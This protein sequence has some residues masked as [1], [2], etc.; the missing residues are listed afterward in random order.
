MPDGFLPAAA[1]GGS[2]PPMLHVNL[3]ARDLRDPQLA[4]EVADLL[5]EHGAD[6]GRITIEVTESAALDGAQALATLHDLRKL[7]LRVSLDD[8]GTGLSTLSLLHDCPVDEIKLDRSFTQAIQAPGA[9]RVPMAAAVVHLARVLGMHVVAEGVETR[10]QA[11]RLL[12]L[13]YA[14]A[15]GNWFAEPASPEAFAGLLAGGLPDRGLRR[16]VKSHS[17][18]SSGTR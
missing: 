4:G 12:A 1:P 18:A 13:G 7:G 9:D 11:E 17:V 8:F 16:T 10:E 6:A 5:A 15:Q 3:S 14:A 2:V